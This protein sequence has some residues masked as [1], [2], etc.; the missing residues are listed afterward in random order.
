M[1]FIVDENHIAW[2]RRFDAGHRIHFDA[3]L[4]NQAGSYRLSNLP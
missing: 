3:V 1:F 4:A 2:G